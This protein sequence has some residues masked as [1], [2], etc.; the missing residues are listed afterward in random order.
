MT[1]KEG[2]AA[3]AERGP[4]PSPEIMIDTS[5]RAST[6]VQSLDPNPWRDGWRV[7]R[8]IVTE[9]F[10]SGS[11]NARLDHTTATPRVDELCPWSIVG[12]FGAHSYRGSSAFG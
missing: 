6:D 11:K 12:A 1:N 9:R 3:G 4:C 5:A 7:L 10:A 2:P 8:T